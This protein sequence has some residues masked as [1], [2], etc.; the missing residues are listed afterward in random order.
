MGVPKGLFAGEKNPA[1]R[2]G[3][4]GYRGPN[5]KSQRLLALHRDG[6]K[7]LA[8]GSV[9]QL[10][11][12]HIIPFRLFAS[13]VEANDLAN[14]ATLC[15]PCHSTTDNDFWRRNPLFFAVPRW[16]DCRLIRKCRRCSKPFQ[17]LPHNFIC[18]PCV[19][20][21]CARCGER[22]IRRRLR[23]EK[24]CS[25]D[26]RNSAVRSLAR[27]CPLCGG[28]KRQSAVRCHACYLKDPAAEVRPGRRP[29][30]KAKDRSA[31]A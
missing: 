27:M 23:A 21:E 2:G 19:T 31:A 8:C 24:Y 16:P 15:R 18:T 28:R 22:F 6:H 14:L 11:V 5:W 9:K 3:H 29:G 12:N 10:T 4:R 1:W 13:H 26:C 7:C 17:A 30:R 20:F 25:R